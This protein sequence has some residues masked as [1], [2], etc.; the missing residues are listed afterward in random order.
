MKKFPMQPFLPNCTNFLSWVFSWRPGSKI[1]SEQQI[2]Q[3]LK[4]CKLLWPKWKQQK[5]PYFAALSH[6]TDLNE[7]WQETVMWNR[8]ISV[9]H[10]FHRSANLALFMMFKMICSFKRISL[11]LKSASNSR[12]RWITVNNE[13][14]ITMKRINWYKKLYG[15]TN[16]G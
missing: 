15:N 16:Q 9:L 12:T 6:V 4:Q 14:W 5:W 8:L 13:I 2:R 3:N 10:K 1:L 11:N 7:M